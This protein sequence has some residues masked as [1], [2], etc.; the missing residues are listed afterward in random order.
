MAESA[1][2]RARRL[3]RLRRWRVEHRAE[4]AAKKRA[5]L[6]AN[7]V[8]PLLR[9][10]RHRAKRAGLPF[11]LTEADVVVPSHCPVLGIPLVVGRSRGPKD[12]SPT[13]DRLDPALGY[14]RGNV[15]VISWKANTIKSNGTPEEHERIAAWMRERAT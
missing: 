5:A 1:E 2:S 14:V 3:D 4:Q 6:E 7:P 13:L 15:A 12:Q 11:E 8:G 9:G 10:A